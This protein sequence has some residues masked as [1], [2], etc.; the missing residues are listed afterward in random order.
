MK[1]LLLLLIILGSSRAVFSQDKQKILDLLEHQRQAWNKGDMEGYMNGY[2]NSDS[3]LFVGSKGPSY[4]WK[5]TL[6]NY[7]QSYPDKAAMGILTFDIREVRFLNDEYAFV[8]GRWHLQR[9]KDSPE[10]YFTLLVRKIDGN[11]KVIADH[12]S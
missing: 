7:L 3:L 11:W 10:G 12:S 8:L 9:T 5:K 6:S 1:R 2:W 4:G